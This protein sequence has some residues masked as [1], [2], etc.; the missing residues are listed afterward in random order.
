[1]QGI[2]SGPKVRLP[3]VRL[4]DA[5]WV[6]RCPLVY[7]VFAEVPDASTIVRKNS[8]STSPRAP[9]PGAQAVSR[10]DISFIVAAHDVAPYVEAAVR[11]ALQQ[12]GVEV[13]VIVVDDASSDSTADIVAAIAASDPR[14]RLIRRTTSGGP[15]IAR[16]EAI[17]R[18]SGG[19]L[20]ILDGDDLIAPERSRHLIDLAGATGADLVG[21][22]F[23]RFSLE[24]AGVGGTMIPRGQAPYAFFVDVAS[25]IGGNTVLRTRHLNFRAIKPVFRAEFLAAK[26][27]GYI[28]DLP[29]GEDYH[30]CLACL[31]SGGR[32]VVTSE[33][34]YKYRVRQGSQ[35]ERLREE[36]INLL[37]KAHAQAGVERTWQ[38]DD[39]V[40][41]TGRDYLR[42]LER[43][44]T[45]A[46]IVDQLK[47]HQV[48]SALRAAMLT[49]DAW[50]LILRFG[51]E[52]ITKRLRRLA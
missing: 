26:S 25:F 46:R 22:N 38:D 9:E 18:A 49:P 5:P 45:F 1:M 28:S 36:H 41:A 2:A 27:I 33:S 51:V 47:N 10:P 50:Q 12:R 6:G 43:A 7:G 29:I 32:F 20:A 16:T 31:T 21:D 17:A 8:E 34:F 35:S 15:S 42:A 14:V 44:R 3:K 52:A 40:A 23:E 48:G 13:E 19:W 30:I 37:L 4:T 39:K 11:S 24:R